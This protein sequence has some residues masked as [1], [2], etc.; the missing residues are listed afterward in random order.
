MKRR[1]NGS[2][3]RRIVLSH[4]DAAQALHVHRNTVGP[5]LRDL[6]ERGFIHM[7][8]GPCLGSS[9]IGPSAL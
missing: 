9:G 4:R 5:W 6:V 1:Y 3:S 2:D 8:Q 7:A